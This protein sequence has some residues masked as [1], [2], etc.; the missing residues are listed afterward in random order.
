MEPISIVI[1]VRIDS[2]ERKENLHCVLQYLLQTPFIYIDILE[3]DQKQ[4]FH[5]HPHERKRSATAL[6]KI[7][8]PYFIGH[9]I[10]IFY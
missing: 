10:L 3:A 9:V 4:H 6:F 8:R 5:F 2:T 1:P 7:M